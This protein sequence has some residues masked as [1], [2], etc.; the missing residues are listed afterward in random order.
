MIKTLPDKLK[1][2]SCAAT[3]VLL[4]SS[5]ALFSA[6]VSEK[7]L[8]NDLNYYHKVSREKSL[9][10]N[11]RRYI[12]L[13]IEEK[14]RGSNVSLAPLRAEI[15]KLKQKQA[16]SRPPAA[17]APAARKTV[18]PQAQATAPAPKPQSMTPTPPAGGV[19]SISTQETSDDSRVIVVAEGVKRSNYFLL[20]DPEP[21]QQ[22]KIV[23]DL[24][25][26]EDTLPT[27]AKDVRTET[28]VFSRVRMGQFK[29]KPDT[30]V[31][32]VAEMREERPCRV[33]TEEGRWVIVAD[34]QPERQTVVTSAEEPIPAT[35]PSPQET[36]GNKTSASDYLI[37]SGDVLS[38]SVFPAE[39]LSREVVVQTDGN[40][41]FPLIGSVKAKNMT[42]K[43]LQASLT[44]SLS[45]YV[46]SPQVTVTV[47]QFSRRQLFIT[48][49]VRAVGTYPFKENVRLL[50]FIS[51]LGG[52][53]D[54]ANRREIR[55][56]R[57]NSAQ[58]QTHVVDVEDII[59]SGDFSKDFKLEPGDIIEV[60]QGRSRI[61]VL[62]DVRNPGYY[63]HR[64]N[65]NLVELISLAGGF[66]DNAELRKVRILRPGEDNNRHVTMV[67]LKA[68]LAGE[69][70]D[71]P[72]QKGETVYVPKGGLA[73]ASWFINNVLPW[74]SLV[75]L[76]VVISG[77]V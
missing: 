18:K 49:E 3:A 60:P 65:I 77:G 35:I 22:P 50:E 62:G 63:D 57:G 47:K 13:R 20:K 48:G 28:G 67:N 69:A 8:Q 25:G 45:R 68:I 32:I 27:Q 64:D 12:L 70:K 1:I 33:V 75:S 66:T 46:S 51:S 10:A 14:Y 74:L 61:A 11:D 73:G 26:I 7:T 59:R 24:Y 2:L 38:V 37:E 43:D 34:K 16:A 29:E 52:F 76:L 9:N 71:I 21:G 42:P 53:T 56:Y 39:E 40:I 58:R 36:A 30:I 31:R 44:R 17:P 5:A 6:D 55:V 19:R 23:L 54:N 15:R 41:P 4:F 72:I